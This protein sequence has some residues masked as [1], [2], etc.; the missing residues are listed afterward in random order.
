MLL[1]CVVF[2]VAPENTDI[3]RLRDNFDL[4]NLSEERTCFKSPENPSRIEKILLGMILFLP[5]GPEPFKILVLLRQVFLI[6]II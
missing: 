1:S 3:K 6:F 5:T 2:S 4:T